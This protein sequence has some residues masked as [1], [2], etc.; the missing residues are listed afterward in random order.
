MYG[1]EDELGLGQAFA[2]GVEVDESVGDVYA[3]R[4][5][6]YDDLGV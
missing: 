4:G 2:L 6:C 1:F 5:T 3:R